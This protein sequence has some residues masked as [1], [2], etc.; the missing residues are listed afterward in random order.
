M[1]S[2]SLYLKGGDSMKMNHL[3]KKAAALLLAVAM[4]P[5]SALAVTEDSEFLNSLYY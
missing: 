2:V 5:V 1:K 3:I 4:L